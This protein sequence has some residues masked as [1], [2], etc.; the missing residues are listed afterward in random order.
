MAMMSLTDD[1]T[2][3]MTDNPAPWDPHPTA[4]PSLSEVAAPTLDSARTN[5]S[6]PSHLSPP[7]D[8]PLLLP[9]PLEAAAAAVVTVT[10]RAQSPWGSE[11][12][13]LPVIGSSG[14]STRASQQSDGGGRTIKH[15]GGGVAGRGQQQHPPEAGTGGESV[16]PIK[17][18]KSNRARSKD[19]R[20]GRSTSSGTSSRKRGDSAPRSPSRSSRPCHSDSSLNGGA[21]APASALGTIPPDATV[22]QQRE[23][24]TLKAQPPR[25]PER[26][27][28]ENRGSHHTTKSSGTSGRKA[29]VSPG[30]WK[31]P[32]SDKLPSTLRSGSSTVSR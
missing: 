14:G 7:P 13:V 15:Q 18:S 3:S 9:S 2:P 17:A 27:S 31:I 25:E 32:G 28:K 12:G 24:L 26:S 29:T 8:P 30:P 19:R 23:P 5:P 10:E 11:T 6:P 20:D 21:P 4:S 1:V 22:S 16:E